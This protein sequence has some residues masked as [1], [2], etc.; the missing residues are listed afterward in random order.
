MI[1]CPH[2]GDGGAQRVAA[3]L[4]SAWSR[5][6]LRVTFVTLFSAID[7]VELDASVRLVALGDRTRRKNWLAAA[8]RRLRVEPVRNLLTALVAGLHGLHLAVALRRVIQRE[9]APRVVSFVG[10]SN[11]IAIWATA[12][13]SCRLVISERNDPARQLLK[14]PWSWLRPRFYDLA[15]S[16]TANSRG[17]LET[18]KAYVSPEK[19]HFAPNPLRAPPSGDSSRPV[20]DPDAP[21]VL[22]VGRLDEQKAHDVLLDALALATKTLPTWR[23][24][25]VGRGELEE[26]LRARAEQLGIG[27]RVTW[28][29]Q[30]DDPFV[31]YRAA[32]VFALPSRH[33]GM[34]NALMEA[35]ASGLPVIVSDASPGPLELVEHDK[36]GLIVPVNDAAALAVALESLANDPGTRERLG[37]A[38]RERVSEYEL[39]RALETWNRILEL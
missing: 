30:V 34:P 33:E 9:A 15:D 35:M 10:S 22:I 7:T 38:A 11:L 20:R 37:K 39:P 12:G 31:Y 25:V 1:V 19:L 16:V 13:L 2:L 32:D 3:T 27:S 21:F 23:L 18:M 4:A 26:P 36:T 5:G 28:C 14:P 8:V 17:A 29:G 24:L 6:G